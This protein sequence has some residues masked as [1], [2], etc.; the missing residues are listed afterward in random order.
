MKTI[1]KV[2][3]GILVLWLGT[4]LGGCG[5]STTPLAESPTPTPTVTPASPSPIP[6]TPTTPAPTPEVQAPQAAQPL[7]PP[8]SDDR[9]K[10]EFAAGSSSATVDGTLANKAIDQYTFEATA[11]QTATISIDSPNQ[12]VLLTLVS[13]S[14]SPIQRYQSGLSSWSGSLPESGIYRVSAVATQ[15]SSYKLNITILPKK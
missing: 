11:N 6:T 3:P 5:Q 4:I 15:A 9:K 8:A 10:I 7:S 2:Y 13:P 12:A 14:G 1:C